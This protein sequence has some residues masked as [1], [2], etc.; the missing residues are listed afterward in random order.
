[1]SKKIKV[2]LTEKQYLA[3]SQA[4]ASHIFDISAPE[5]Q[6][7]IDHDLATECRVIENGIKAMDKGYE[8][9]A[10]KR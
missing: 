10:M 7:S 4:L 6:D 3:M 8:E 5:F 1:M 2:E 9:W